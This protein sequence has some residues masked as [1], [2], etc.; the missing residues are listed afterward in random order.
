MNNTKKR[1]VEIAKNVAECTCKTDE[2]STE[3]I[4]KDFPGKEC[5]KKR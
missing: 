2:L 1:Q 5:Q 4:E 3:I